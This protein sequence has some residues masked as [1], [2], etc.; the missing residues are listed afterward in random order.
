MLTIVANKWK[1]QKYNDRLK[2]KWSLSFFL[3]LLI[4]VTICKTMSSPYINVLWISD[5][6]FTYYRHYY[7]VLK[8][9]LS[10]SNAQ[11]TSITAGEIY[12]MKGENIK[13]NNWLRGSGY[14]LIVVSWSRKAYENA[15]KELI[16]AG[17]NANIPVLLIP[18]GISDLG[19]PLG[20]SLIHI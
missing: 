13:F 6:P 18:G 17:I 2:D 12:I 16:I 10:S 4:M 5:I 15:V 20:L 19:I 3:I 11:I 9:V 14:D 1:K 7:Q 8:E